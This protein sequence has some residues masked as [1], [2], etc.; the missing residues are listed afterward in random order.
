MLRF[1]ELKTHLF[2]K[3]KASDYDFQELVQRLDQETKKDPKNERL[4]RLQLW[5]LNLRSEGHQAS[6]ELLKARSR[7]AELEGICAGGD[8][9]RKGAMKIS[10]REAE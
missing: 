2:Y 5:Y 9:E 10:R 1:A 4:Y 6:E 7:V 3:A 8:K